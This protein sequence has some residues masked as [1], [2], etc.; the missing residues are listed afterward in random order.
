MYFSS[1]HGGCDSRWG[2]T[3]PRFFECAGET[4]NAVFGQDNSCSV[5]SEDEGG[6]GWRTGDGGHSWESDSGVAPLNTYLYTI[7]PAEKGRGSIYVDEADQLYCPVTGG[8]L[9]V[10]L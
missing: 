4:T 6:P 10:G 3:R 7:D 2:Y 9:L 8:R 5:Y 1:M